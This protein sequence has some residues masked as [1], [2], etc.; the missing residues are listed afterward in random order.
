MKVR[1]KDKPEVTGYADRFN[2]HAVSPMEI[3]VG[4]DHGDMDSAYA[5]DY[6]CFIEATQSWVSVVEAF[7]R[8][9]LITD[10]YNTRF[11]EP[12]TPEDAERGYTL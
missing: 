7:G 1:L 11:F 5:R 2:T 8:R 4:F 10:N 6:E 9:L 12:P 3:I